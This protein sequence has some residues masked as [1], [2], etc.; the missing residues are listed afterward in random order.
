M[1]CQTPST[2]VCPSCNA[3]LELQKSFTL[4]VVPSNQEIWD[5]MKYAAVSFAPSEP[6]TPA[7]EP[8]STPAPET[9]A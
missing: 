7:V 4:A 6:A 9:N 5:G 1:N 3:Q 2:L 8:E